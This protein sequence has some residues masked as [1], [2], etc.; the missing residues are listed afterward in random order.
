MNLYRIA[1]S[2]YIDDLAG[3]G[4]LYANGRWHSKGTRI[5]YFSEHISLAKLEVLANSVVAP[6][7]MSLMTLE[8]KQSVGMETI[9]SNELPVG[10]DGYPY[11]EELQT[12]TAKWITNNNALILKVPSA[13]AENEYNFLINPLHAEMKNIEVLSVQPIK[14]D[15]RLKF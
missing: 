10:W 12:L 14:F 9:A 3:N 1:R 8:I 15:R 6:K 7:D 11:L 13:Q 5:L 4:G 2:K